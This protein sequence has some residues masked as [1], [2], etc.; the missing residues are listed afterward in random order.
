[1]TDL[2]EST[3]TKHS[4][5]GLVLGWL[6]ALIFSVAGVVALFQSGQ[7]ITGVFLILAALVAL[8]P[9]QT[10]LK[11]KARERMPKQK[12]LLIAVGAA[13]LSTSAALTDTKADDRSYLPPQDL[14]DQA[15]ESGVQAPQA[16]AGLRNKQYVTPPRYMRRHYAQRHTRRHFFPGIFFSLLR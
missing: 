8:P 11:R 6:F 2:Q 15:K 7:F 4:T 14:Q 9:A 13:M 5:L 12:K 3:V 1:M 10:F 16:E